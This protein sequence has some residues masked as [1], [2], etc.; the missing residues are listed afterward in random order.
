MCARSVLQWCCP[1]RGTRQEANHRTTRRGVER[2]DG[3]CW[4]KSAERSSIGKSWPLAPLRRYRLAHTLRGRHTGAVLTVKSRAKHRHRVFR[5][6]C[7]GSSIQR[8][9]TGSASMDR[10]DARHF[11]FDDIQG[12]CSYNTSA[13]DRGS[14]RR[15]TPR[16]SRLNRQQVRTVLQKLGQRL[17]PVFHL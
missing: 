4:G 12:Q 9:P 13:C 3:T 14:R 2:N 16:P 1:L 17:S 10:G 15:F 6:A 7:P 8:V 5:A 11:T